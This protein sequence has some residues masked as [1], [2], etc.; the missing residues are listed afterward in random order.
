MER[1]DPDCWCLPHLLVKRL[2][3][4]PDG[5]RFDGAVKFAQI[6][7][8]AEGAMGAILDVTGHWSPTATEKTSVALKVNKS[9]D[10]TRYTDACSHETFFTFFM[11]DLLAT[12]C[13]SLH[14]LRPFGVL[15]LQ[16][17]ATLPKQPRRPI[18]AL[19]IE[20][21]NG[22]ETTEGKRVFNL[23]DYILEGARGHI[24]RFEE[25]FF[26]IIFQVLFTIHTW[27]ILTQGRVRHNDLYVKNIGL[28]IMPDDAPPEYNTH[29]FPSAPDKPFISATFR[30]PSG[31]KLRAVVLDFGWAAALPGLGPAHDQRFVYPESRG[32]KVCL[33]QRS[34]ILNSG[35]SQKLPSH[36][37]D[38]TLFMYS[39]SAAINTASKSTS[40]PCALKRFQRMYAR[41]YGKLYASSAMYH[42]ALCGRLTTAVQRSLLKS[43]RLS[44]KLNGSKKTITLPTAQDLLLD[45]VFAFLRCPSPTPVS[46]MAFGLRSPVPSRPLPVSDYIGVDLS[47]SPISPSTVSWRRVL[48][49]WQQPCAP[50]ETLLSSIHEMYEF[51]QKK[52]TRPHTWPTP[53][54][55]KRKRRTPP[56]SSAPKKRVR[57]SSPTDFSGMC[58]TTLVAT[59][60]PTDLSGLV[61]TT[62]TFVSTPLDFQLAA[63]TILCK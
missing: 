52:E 38:S 42:G 21:L 31:S 58:R 7:L 12:R 50:Y 40:L 24:D 28:S 55:P 2:A 37:Y 32:G 27:T 13:A 18:S 34:I 53:T 22:A 20:R 25:S 47:A 45:G 11:W 6:N 62:T 19:A 26:I 49:R 15:K 46:P 48:G 17:P 43:S 23:Y 59:S 41:H 39:I 33:R 51:W 9:S 14:V 35:M 30:L 16:L 60:T 4:E 54:K 8:L 3:S 29:F 61:S 1:S 56:I 63:Q 57:V 36:H 5:P 44:Y 10:G